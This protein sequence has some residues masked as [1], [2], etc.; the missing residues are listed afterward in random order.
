MVSQML[1][2]IFSVDA[3]IHFKIFSINTLEI[4][5][6]EIPWNIRKLLDTNFAQFSKLKKMSQK[7]TTNHISANILIKFYQN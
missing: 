3:F 1:L 6:N 7:K 4:S 5:E 2:P